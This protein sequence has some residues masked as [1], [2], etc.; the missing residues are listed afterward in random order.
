LP[1]AVLQR[2]L[3]RIASGDFP[4]PARRVYRLEDVPRAHADI[5]QNRGVGKIVVVNQ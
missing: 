1:A 4:A 3:D 5:E 2:V